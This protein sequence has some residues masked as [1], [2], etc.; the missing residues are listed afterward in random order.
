MLSDELRFLAYVTTRLDRAGIAYM[1]TGSM[2]MMFYA[3]PRMTRD[4]DLVVECQDEDIDAL[5]E[6]FAEDCYISAAAVRDAVNTRGMF[7]VIHTEMAIKAD[8]VVRRATDYRKLEFSRSR[9]VDLDGL[10][11]TVVSPEDLILSK[12]DWARDSHS[13][14]Q[15]RDVSQLLRAV[16]GLDFAY[17]DNW[18]REL[19]VAAKLKELRL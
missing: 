8:F 17:L 2:A 1:L 19:D 16:P 6:A 14:S 12:L 7:N 4:I 10:V 9:V 3:V 5:V 11:V 15:Y 18:A 13:E